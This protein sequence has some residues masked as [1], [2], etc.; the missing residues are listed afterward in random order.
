M[1]EDVRY[2]IGKYIAQPFSDTLFG[3]WLIDIKNLPQHLENAVL[4]LD[5]QQLDT[6]YRQGGWTVKQLVHHVADSHMN[7]YIRFKL[8]LTEDNPTIK[9]Y[10]E[11][12]WA[13]MNDTKNL[14]INISLTLLHSLHIRWYQILN[15]MTAADLNRTVF[16]PEHKKQ[17]TLWEL[18]GL[19]AWHGKHHS[20]HITALREKMNW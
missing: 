13:M 18:L 1:S 15:G 14:P 20:A 2:P 4:N 9:P 5:E 16:H 11:N 10:D 7:A 8:G 19:Y 6:T 12:A 17:F 3:E